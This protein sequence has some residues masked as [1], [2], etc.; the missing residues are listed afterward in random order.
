MMKKLVPF[1]F[2]LFCGVA[3]SAQVV[4]VEYIHNLIQN[5][6]DITIPYNPELPNPRVVANMKYL[7]TAIDVAN[8]MLNGGKWTNYG[9]GE[10]ATNQVADTVAV[11]TAVM[12]LIQRNASQP[13]EPNEDVWDDGVTSADFPFAME[14]VDGTTEFTFLLTAAGQFVIDWGDG[15][16]ETI[17]KSDIS[18][19]E[20]IHRYDAPGAYVVKIGGRATQY[21]KNVFAS[22]WVPA[23]SA[24]WVTDYWSLAKLYGRLG[25][26]FG[27]LEDGTQPS[28]AGAFMYCDALTTIPE[29]LFDGITGDIDEY[30]FYSMFE[31]TERLSEIPNGL[32]DGLTGELKTGAFNYMFADCYRLSGNSAK[33]NGVYLYK[34]WPNATTDQVGGMYM[35]DTGLSDWVSIPSAWK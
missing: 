5:K 24:I 6:W 25:R 26:V 30:M 34:R 20:I 17:S 11:D 23:I 27:T 14:L 31:G 1:L 15:Y 12:N 13:D 8:E 9:N 18:E 4:N 28:F 29:T 10:Y 33:I 21:D 3:Q 16:T 2:T 35:N 19:K 32:F 22:A 7:L